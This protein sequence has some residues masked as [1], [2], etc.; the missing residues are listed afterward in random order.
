MFETTSFSHDYLIPTTWPQV[1]STD[2]CSLVDGAVPVIADL[3]KAPSHYIHPF[4]YFFVSPIPSPIPSIWTILM[5]KIICVC[6]KI[7]YLCE[8]VLG[9]YTHLG[10]KLLGHRVYVYLIGISSARFFSWVTLPVCTASSC[11]WEL[12]CTISLL[13]VSST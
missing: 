10:G 13:P 7:M 11:I 2:G 12:L 5:Q 1:W 9:T 6:K 8:G 3:C 4:I